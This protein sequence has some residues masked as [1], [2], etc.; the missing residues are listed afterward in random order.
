MKNRDEILSDLISDT[1]AQTNKITYFGKDSAI[2]G[3]FSAISFGLSEVWNDVFQVKRQIQQQT[4]LGED[5][6]E[7][8][9]RKGLTRKGATK[10][11]VV[12]NFSG[13]AGTVIPQG[14][15][16]KSS[17]TLFEYQTLQS[18]TL[19]SQNPAIQRPISSNQIAD[20][21]LAESVLT[22]AGARVGAGELNL[23]GSPINGVTV[24]NLL[25]SSGGIDAESD[26]ELRAR[27]TS[28]GDGLAQGTTAFYEELSRKANPDVLR[29]KAKF[30][31]S[32][33]G[34][35]LYLIK[36]SLA[37][38]S[39]G[40]L[41]AI[42]T[43]IFE[44]QRACN[45]V[46]CFNAGLVG[47]DIELFFTLKAGEDFETVYST[48]ANVV[49]NHIDPSLSQFGGSINYF[50]LFTKLATTEGILN[51]RNLL[52]NG[53][54][55]GIRLNE[56]QLPRVNILVLHDVSTLLDKSVTISQSFIIG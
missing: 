32:N 24:I 42:A 35:K 25:P 4:A 31:P 54:Q 12:L 13:E 17:V 38:F 26:E 3:I 28:Y 39:Q 45:P 29:A 1:V 15:T 27:I 51:I 11:T 41:D 19:G 9:G 30:D 22:G 7:L 52:L 53:L 34:V 16:V 18:I 56:T 10:S 20:V 8:A 23:L 48:V 33:Y 6:D 50:D 55:E 14:T 44:N 47:I 21:V 40:E 43:Y 5:L 37:T 46:R 36:N 49:T 2:R